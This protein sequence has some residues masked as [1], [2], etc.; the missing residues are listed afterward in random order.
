MTRNQ[1]DVAT[2][3]LQAAVDLLA[4]GRSEDQI[5]ARALKGDPGTPLDDVL[6]QH[7]SPHE[8]AILL[9][10]IGLRNPAGREKSFA[11]AQKLNYDKRFP[12]LLLKQVLASQPAN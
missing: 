1:P 12:H 8:K 9:A 7:Q 5:F 10:A 3:H 11:L 2:R 4:K 6:R